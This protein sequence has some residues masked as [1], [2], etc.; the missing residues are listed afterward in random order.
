MTNLIFDLDGVIIT[1]EKNFAETY[2]EEF[3]A[4]VSRIYKFFADDY[5]ECAVGSASL[6]ERIEK[7]VLPWGW[8]GDAQSLIQYWFDAQSEVDARL[9]DLI[10][11]ARQSGHKCYVASDQDKTRSAYV[12]KL[13]NVDDAFDGSF[14]SCDLGAT[15]TEAD[16]FERMLGKLACDPEDVF[17][18][19]DN[20]KN[21]A[22]AKQ[23]GIR[24]EIYSSFEN[25]QVQFSRRFL[26]AQ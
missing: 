12:R 26:S 7:Y 3:G 9:L 10:G 4:D 8:P 22:V 19:D 25:F 6:H 15:K 24:A 20:P 13:V 21:V 2:S 5:H 18:W 16:F 1:Y 23:A 14:F 11:L 17:F